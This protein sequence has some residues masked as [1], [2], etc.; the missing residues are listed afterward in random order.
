MDSVYVCVNIC[1]CVVF[2]CAATKRKSE[3]SSAAKAEEDGLSSAVVLQFT[4]NC[5]CISI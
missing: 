4:V 1:M 5:V 2:A 3:N